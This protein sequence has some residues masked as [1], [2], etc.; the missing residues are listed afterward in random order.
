MHAASLKEKW[1]INIRNK[2]NK[3]QELIIRTSGHITKSNR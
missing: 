2:I 3:K 1:D